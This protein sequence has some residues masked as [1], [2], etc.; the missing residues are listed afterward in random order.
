VRGRHGDSSLFRFR[1]IV[2]RCR[3]A[4]NSR[5]SQQATNAAN[6]SKKQRAST[7]SLKSVQPCNT[8]RKRTTGYLKSRKSRVVG[9]REPCPSSQRRKHQSRQ[10]TRGSHPHRR[11]DL[12]CQLSTIS[13]SLEGG[14]ADVFFD[15]RCICSG[16]TLGPLMRFEITDRRRVAERKACPSSRKSVLYHPASFCQ[17]SFLAID[18]LTIM[19]RNSLATIIR[20]ELASDFDL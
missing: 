19:I 5:S 10:C 8:C 2:F 18:Q 13:T 4:T 17:C 11:H 14:R 20:F 1:R 7:L 12:P 3:N 15:M 16:R 6:A 9:A